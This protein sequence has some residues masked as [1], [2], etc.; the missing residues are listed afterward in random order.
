MRVELRF[1]TMQHGAQCVT[2]CG[3]LVMLMWPADNLD[4]LLLVCSHARAWQGSNVHILHQN[5]WKSLVDVCYNK[6]GHSVWWNIWSNVGGN[7]HGLQATYSLNWCDITIT[8]CW[9]HAG[10]IAHSSAIFGQGTGPIWLD[11]VQCS[12]FETTL[13]SCR[14]NGVGV[15]N[16]YHF[17]D[18]GVTCQGKA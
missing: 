8:V 16:C 7:V 12:G 14:N 4:S 15:H 2:T 10:A 1:A 9:L 3:T 11:N 13:V 17:E 18:A 5:Q 6:C